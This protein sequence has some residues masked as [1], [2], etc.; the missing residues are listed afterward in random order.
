[1]TIFLPAVRICKDASKKAPSLLRCFLL[2]NL[3]KEETR[4]W[5]RASFPSLLSTERKYPVKQSGVPPRSCPV[6]AP[7]DRT[8]SR[9]PAGR[10]WLRT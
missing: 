2:F 1:M 10:D 9:S 5:Q 8:G 7:Q 4:R 3:A 6:R